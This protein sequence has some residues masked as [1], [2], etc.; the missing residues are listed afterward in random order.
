[1]S[2]A[3]QV[4]AAT[5]VVRRRISARLSMRRRPGAR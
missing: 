2:V 5:I 1:L 3:A 4:I